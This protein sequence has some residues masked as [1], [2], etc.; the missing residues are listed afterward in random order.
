MARPNGSNGYTAQQFISAIPGTGGIITAIANKV[1]C[2]WHTAKKYIDEYAT[3]RTAW[4]NERNR[5]TDIAQ[6]NIIV[7]VIDGDL[8]MSKWW[9]QVMDNDF[10]PPQKQ[11]V[12]GPL[13]SPIEIIEIVKDYGKPNVEPD[14]DSE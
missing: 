14:S 2:A 5:I 6:D 13:G 4:Q 1:G 9:L 3:V 8:Q 7:S 11:E 12:S 10:N